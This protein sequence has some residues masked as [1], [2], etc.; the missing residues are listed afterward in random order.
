MPAVAIVSE[1][2]IAPRSY[3][4]LRGADAVETGGRPHRGRRQRETHADPARSETPST[5]GSTSHGNR[6]IARPPAARG[7]RTDVAVFDGTR[8][9]RSMGPK[10]PGKTACLLR[11]IGLMMAAPVTDH[12]VVRGTIP[13]AEQRGAS[14][15]KSR[16]LVSCGLVLAFAGAS[17]AFAQMATKVAFQTDREEDGNE[18]GNIRIYL[19]NEN[20]SN[21]EA[22]TD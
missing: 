22:L 12:G 6:E 21:Q 19:M 17:A 7:T 20:G 9:G 5:H 13:Q 3:G 11:S 2:V 16:Y 15:K 8:Q 10:G 14:M 1:R 18:D 4:P